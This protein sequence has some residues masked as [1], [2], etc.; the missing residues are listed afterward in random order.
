MTPDL[1]CKQLN[2]RLSGRYLLIQHQRARNAHLMKKLSYNLLGNGWDLQTYINL[3][4]YLVDG[5]GINR[6]HELG[7]C[8]SAS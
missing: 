8:F 1:P 5:D 3:I 2:G 7:T 6:Q 4:V